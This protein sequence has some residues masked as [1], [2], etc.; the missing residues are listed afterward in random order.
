MKPLLLSLL[1]LLLVLAPVTGGVGARPIPLPL[2]LPLLSL[3]LVDT[4]SWTLGDIPLAPLGLLR[5]DR[6]SSRPP[7]QP[8]RLPPAD[9]LLPL[10]LPW[11]VRFAFLGGFGGIVKFRTNGAQLGLRSFVL[12]EGDIALAGVELGGAVIGGSDTLAPI[13]TV[14][15]NDTDLLDLSAPVRTVVAVRRHDRNLTGLCWATGC[16]TVS[17]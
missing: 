13:C 1:P 10:L 16:L 2:A 12:G 15:A 6:R 5:P 8:P 14:D 17:S 3:T 9:P 4:S 7:W 11:T